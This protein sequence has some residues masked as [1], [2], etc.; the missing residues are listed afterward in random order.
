M[1]T[2]EALKSEID[3]T[4]EPLLQEVYDFLIL[5]KGRTARGNET[6]HSSE[7]KELSPK[8]PDF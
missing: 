6:P 1:S 8:L 2:A 4:P 3:N 7:R 5:L